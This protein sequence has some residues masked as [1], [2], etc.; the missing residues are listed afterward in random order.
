M[1]NQGVTQDQVSQAADRLVQGGQDPS[2]KAIREL[3]GTGSLTTISKYLKVW[4]ADRSG[5]G[6]SVAPKEVLGLPALRMAAPAEIADH[7]EG[8]H[9]QVAAVIVSHLP[10]KDSAEVLKLLAP[11]VSAEILDR[12]SMLS[13]VGPRMLMLLNANLKA[14]FSARARYQEL[15]NKGGVGA[16]SNIWKHMDPKAREKILSG[17]KQHN[18]KLASEIAGSGKREE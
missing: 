9:P 5:E 18:P 8:E 6:E 16:V 14:E 11:A 13:F 1:A 17:I 10:P 12:L 3:L 7:L 2:I 4:K 15:L